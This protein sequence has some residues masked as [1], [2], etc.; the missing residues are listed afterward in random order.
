M[1][2]GVVVRLETVE[3][4]QRQQQRPIA[5]RLRDPALEIGDEAA[6]IGEAGQRVVQRLVRQLLGGTLARGD[7]LHLRDRVARSA[8]LAVDEREADRDPQRVAFGVQVAHLELRVLLF[9]AR[10]ATDSLQ[11][12]GDV[13][14]M[15][16]VA[17]GARAQLLARTAGQLAHRA[18]DL[19]DLAGGLVGEAEQDHADRGA[20][21]RA[22]EALLALAGAPV[23]LLRLRAHR[24]VQAPRDDACDPRGGDEGP[25]DQRP[26]PRVRLRVRMVV[27]AAGVQR[28]HHAVVDD[29]VRDGDEEGDPVLVEREHDDRHEEQE[30]RLDRAVPDVDEQRAR[31]DEA[32]RD[33]R[34]GGAPAMLEQQRE[35]AERNQR[36]GVRG[37]VQHGVALGDAEE[38]QAERLGEQQAD[39]RMMPAAPRVVRER[40]ALRKRRAKRPKHAHAAIFGLLITK[41]ESRA[42]Y[43]V[44][45]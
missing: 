37:A 16:D 29:D 3:V 12:G 35:D 21:E 24:L 22:L 30:V 44:A 15:D 14:G 41:L 27:D 40:V 38:R 32:E 20:L 2:E 17:E 18:I 11:A 6:P 25:M 26:L 43:G 45:P 42:R 1:P 19:Q 39:H 4:E 10:Q 8:R 5:R 13:V 23:G 9:V 36:G 34:R 28:A 33:E 31:R 7:V